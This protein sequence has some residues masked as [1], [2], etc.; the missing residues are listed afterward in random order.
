MAGRRRYCRDEEKS[1]GRCVITATI[2]ARRS[3]QS[4]LFADRKRL[5]HHARQTGLF[6]GYTNRHPYSEYCRGRIDQSRQRLPTKPTNLKNG[7]A[8]RVK[9]AYYHRRYLLRAVQGVRA[10]WRPVTVAAG[11]V[12]R[13][14]SFTGTFCI[15]RG[16][17]GCVYPLCQGAARTRARFRYYGARVKSYPA[18]ICGT[19]GAGAQDLRGWRWW[20]GAP[21]C[22]GGLCSGAP[23]QYCRRSVPTR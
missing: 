16:S 19:V 1:S 17:N 10:F 5:V 9:I 4:P 11:S 23:L 13:P 22:G 12:G 7:G 18:A 8:L 15:R 14:A 21:I 3:W 2:P 20:L 6:V